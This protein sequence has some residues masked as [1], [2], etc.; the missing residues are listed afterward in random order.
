MCV[1][2][3]SSVDSQDSN[4]EDHPGADYGDSPEEEEEEEDES[5]D[6]EESGSGEDSEG[7]G[8]QESAAGHVS[9]QA[10]R[11]RALR[12]LSPFLG[13]DAAARAVCLPCGDDVGYDYV[14]SDED[15][16]VDYDD[17]M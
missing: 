17:E 16:D 6:G 8:G 10:L 15:D 3:G 4:R 11:A 13:A 7:L 12:E 2:A 1:L 14:A 9:M 5:S